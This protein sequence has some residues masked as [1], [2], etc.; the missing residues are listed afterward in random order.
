MSPMAMSFASGA[1]PVTWGK[2]GSSIVLGSKSRLRDCPTMLEAMSV[3]WGGGAFGEVLD[4]GE[5]AVGD[6]VQLLAG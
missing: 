4:D 3:P 6:P 1:M 2:E 5:I